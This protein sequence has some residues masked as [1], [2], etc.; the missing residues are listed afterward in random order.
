MSTTIHRVRT[1][2]TGLL[3]ML[4]LSAVA[5][6]NPSTAPP[7]VEQATPVAAALATTS[8]WPSAGQNL[9]NTRD[10][11]AETIIGPSNVSG[12][13][14]RWHVPTTGYVPGTPTVADGVVYATDLGGTLWA[15]DAATGQVN[16]SHSVGSYLNTLFAVSRNSPAVDGDKLVI[17]TGSMPLT[18][19]TPVGAYLVGVDASSGARL[20]K[21]K[22][23]TDPYATITGSPVIHDGVVYA[24]VSSLD[25]LVDFLTPVFRGKVVAL[26]E[27]TGQVL[28]QTYTA[29]PGYTG[30]A[31]WGSAPVVDPERGLLY[32]ATGNNYTVPPGV[33][34]SP[35]ETGCTPSAADNYFDAVL[36]LDLDT[37]A[38]VW[39][40]KTLTADTA[41]LPSLV[42]GTEGPDYDFGSSPNL[43]TTTIDG[44][45]TE[46]LGIGQKSGIYWALDP[47][48]GD[49]VWQT[50]V[51]PGGLE[52]GILWG[53]ATDGTRVYVALSNFLSPTPYTITSATGQ[54][55]TITGGSWSALDAATGQILWQTADPQGS[56]DMGFM[57][58]ANGVVYA[59]SA[60]V[61]GNTMYALDAAD[62]TILWDFASGGSTI[63]GA[64]IV[65]GSVYWASG[66]FKPA[67]VSFNNLWAFDLP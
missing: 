23:D 16:W 48:T 41:T 58:T 27:D 2:G 7:T 13:T 32:V 60:S 36:A 34:K 21:T 45:A 56:P 4:A 52:G 67:A 26:D 53:S 49:V 6:Q 20:W 14:P 33:C 3:A 24:G 51:G 37:G 8:D 28:W 39:A 65:D 18:A 54:T 12:L 57:S 46:L 66:Y 29:P 11:A 19:V 9:H 63:A 35:T 44:V 1:A 17:G 59:P 50:Q 62:G 61:V 30:N 31:V 5:L 47:D 43:F 25:E 38:V 10:A 40:R 22:I 64:A 15:V 55:S 42:L